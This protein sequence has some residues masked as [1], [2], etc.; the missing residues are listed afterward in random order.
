MAIHPAASPVVRHGESAGTSLDHPHT[1]RPIGLTI[2]YPDGGRQIVAVHEPPC[3]SGRSKTACISL[4]SFEQS[5]ETAV[6]IHYCCAMGNCVSP[7]ITMVLV[8][9]GEYI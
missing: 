5:Y 3:R 1:T 9:V 2:F 7:D 6:A 4:S 8:V